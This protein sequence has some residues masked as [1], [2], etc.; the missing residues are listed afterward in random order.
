MKLS[1]NSMKA[2][3]RDFENE[4]RVVEENISELSYSD[5]YSS[6]YESEENMNKYIS[7]G[8]LDLPSEVKPKAELTGD[9]HK[10][11]H[12][13]I[14]L[15]K[16]KKSFDKISMHYKIIVADFKTMEQLYSKVASE[17][18][19]KPKKTSPE[20]FF[21]SI[22]TFLLSC[23]KAMNDNKREKERAERAEKSR[24]AIEERI[25][26]RKK[27]E[28]KALLANQQRIDTGFSRNG[29][30]LSNTSESL[31]SLDR[32]VSHLK[33]PPNSLTSP[34]KTIDYENEH[35][36]QGVSDSKENVKPTPIVST[37]ADSEST[38]TEIRAEELLDSVIN[39]SL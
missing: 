5:D 11:T 7:V 16:M 12:L 28:A 21:G 10:L 24:R 2:G 26:R 39:Y 9:N 14:Y 17:F 38:D 32:L 23:D 1:L 33:E 18:C 13:K 25:A 6:G 36:K 19:E 15:E 35:T 3:I 29:V 31:K 37:G 34:T 22:R 8:S 27:N 4:I 20:M 30:E